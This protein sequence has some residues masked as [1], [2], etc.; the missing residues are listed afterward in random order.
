MEPFYAMPPK[1]VQ[2]IG[3]RIQRYLLERLYTFSW[4][5]P[6]PSS[7]LI[8]AVLSSPCDDLVDVMDRITGLQQLDGK[9]T[10]YRAAKVI[11]RTRN[12]LKGASLRQADVDPA[13]FQEPLEHQLWERYAAQKD[14]VLRLIQGKAYADATAA[15]GEAFFEVL[16]EFFERVMVNVEDEA[17]QQNRLALM[18]AINALYTERIA[19]LSNLAILQRGVV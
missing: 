2:V 17:L 14:H 7:D 12:I 5:A 15:Y 3:S 13:R 16:H 10:L 9:H 19:D 8:D 18:R 11:E 1:K 6:A 4:P